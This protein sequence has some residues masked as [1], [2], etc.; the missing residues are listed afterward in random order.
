MQEKY[1]NLEARLEEYEK[2]DRVNEISY[3]QGISDTSSSNSE[4][5]LT[6]LKKKQVK[7]KSFMKKSNVKNKH[8]VSLL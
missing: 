4:K 1:Q 8:S 2:Q 3:P 7:L 5:S 6:K